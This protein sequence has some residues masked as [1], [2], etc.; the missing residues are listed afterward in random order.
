[1]KNSSKRKPAPQRVEAEDSSKIKSGLLA[2]SKR[3]GSNAST[4]TV[5]GKVIKLIATCNL[6]ENN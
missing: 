6:W 4:L 3:S 1:M 5:N 2:F